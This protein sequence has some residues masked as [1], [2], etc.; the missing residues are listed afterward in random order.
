MLLFPRPVGAHQL[1][2]VICND[3]VYSDTRMSRSMWFQTCC[4][5]LFTLIFCFVVSL[6][7]A[8]FTCFLCKLGGFVRLSRAC[9]K[10][11]SHVSLCSIVPLLRRCCCCFAV[12]AL[13]F[14]YVFYV[15]PCVRFCMFLNLLSHCS[16]LLSFLTVLH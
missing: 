8:C 1:T 12:F 13:F 9:P 5:A 2:Q 10:L 16:C 15:S 11:S 14:L 6:S 4:F 3:F 7:L